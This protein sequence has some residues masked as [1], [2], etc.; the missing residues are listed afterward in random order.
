M[1]TRDRSSALVQIVGITS[2]IASLIFVGLELR[3]SHKIALAAQQQE[4]SSFNYG[5]NRFIF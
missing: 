5:S 2:L 3:Q 4:K 1:S